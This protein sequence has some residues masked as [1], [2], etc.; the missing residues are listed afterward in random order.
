[1]AGLILLTSARPDAQRSISSRGRCSS[2]SVDRLVFLGD[3]RIAVRVWRGAVPVPSDPAAPVVTPAPV[4]AP[5]PDDCAVPALLVPG[6]GLD[7]FAAPLGS[8]PEL[9][10]PPGF[11][12]PEGMPLKP[13]CP[14][15]QNPH[16]ASRRRCCC[17]PTLP[18][19]LLR[20][21]S[22]RGYQ[23]CDGCDA[24]GGIIP[25]HRKSPFGQRPR[26][27]PC[28]CPERFPCC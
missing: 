20:E 4:L 22:G 9:F 19:A 21:R 3:R 10:N 7:A 23:H 5:P 27:Q 28:S 12:G 1:M 11:A 8:S 25:V 26:R 15:R 6:A 13:V 17:R 16:S 14:R 2:P 24:D 18:P